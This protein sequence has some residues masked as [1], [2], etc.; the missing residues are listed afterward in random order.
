M[1]KLPSDAKPGSNE[2]LVPVGMPAQPR[3]Q[4]RQARSVAMV[5]ALKQAGRQILEEQGREAL[6]A[7]YLAEH[8]GV[9][10]SSIY[11]YFPTMESLIAAIFD[12]YRQQARAELLAAIAEL[13]PEATLFDGLLVTLRIGLA[14]H[15]R[16]LCL[17]PLFSLRSTRYDEL[18]RLELVEARQCWSASA[19]PAL[20]ERFAEEVR[21]KDRGKAQ[22]LVYQTLLML[23]RAMRLERPE[24]LVEADTAQLIARMLHAL[25]TCE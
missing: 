14:V 6:T 9:A 19:T 16:K 21:V 24:F 4:P 1:E 23:P 20:L 2:T 18:V 11:E 7:L 8:S 22:F 3:K 17:D 12:D 15:H 25:L 5:E 13:P 10:I